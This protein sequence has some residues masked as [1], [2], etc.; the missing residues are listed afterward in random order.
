MVQSAS[1]RG[2]VGVGASVGLIV[3]TKRRRKRRQDLGW[4]EPRTQTASG[5]RRPHAKIFVGMWVDR[6]QGVG[7]AGESVGRSA[8]GRHSGWGV[9]VEH[10]VEPT[11]GF[12]W[13]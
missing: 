13:R 1:G 4:L 7:R 8:S 10:G 2:L 6:H 12:C 9:L 3:F 11:V 5:C